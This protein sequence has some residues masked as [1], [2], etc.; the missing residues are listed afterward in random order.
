M[1]TGDPVAHLATQV[2]QLA[3]RVDELAAK[4]AGVDGMYNT[5][6]LLSE[7]I[8]DL[9][10]QLTAMSDATGPAEAIRPCWFP[11]LDATTAQQVWKSLGEWVMT[12]L[13]ERYQ[14]DI[15]PCWY[16]H[17]RTVDV[18]AALYL[19]WKAAY[20]LDGFP[21]APAE[22]HDRWFPHLIRLV[23]AD[24]KGCGHRHRVDEDLQPIL[25][26][27][28]RAE[29]AASDFQAFVDEDVSRRPGQRMFPV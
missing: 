4:I 17:P 20:A 16:R 24:T 19:A 27:P 13:V 23:E 6:E 1:P 7:G 29:Q 28:G 8:A 11:S 14:R 3:N 21:T 22:W 2:S 18:L 25:L 9:A 10:Q 26:E 15:K 5:V 12:V